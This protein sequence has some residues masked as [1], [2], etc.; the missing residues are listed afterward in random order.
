VRDEVRRRVGWRGD[1]PGWLHRAIPAAALL[2]LAG[3]VLIW[4]WPADR[5]ARQA[6]E[7]PTRAPKDRGQVA[8]QAAGALE[9]IGSMAARAGAQ[10]E[11]VISDRA[12]PPLRNSL[13]D[14]EN[15]IIQHIEL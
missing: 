11:K 8:N 5:S 13:Q 3:C 15:K 6:A 7:A 10:S 2:V 9:W 14:A 1:S 4:R 12:V